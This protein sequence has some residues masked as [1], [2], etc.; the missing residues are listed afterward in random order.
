MCD[1]LACSNPSEYKIKDLDG[2]VEIYTC[3]YCIAKT[4]NC[5]RQYKELQIFCL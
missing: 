5:L 3:S 2:H 4:L 1:E